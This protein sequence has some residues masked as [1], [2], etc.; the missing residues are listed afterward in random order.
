VSADDE[1]PAP[2]VSLEERPARRMA[3]RS[4]AL[5]AL[6]AGS[7]AVAFR[8]SD[9]PWPS[10]LPVSLFVA[11]VLL[12]LAL[13]VVTALTLVRFGRLV[14]DVFKNE[15]VAGRDT[16]TAYCAVTV[17]F[18]ISAVAAALAGGIGY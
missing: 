9:S 12:L 14:V 4:V 1:R 11:G 5:L 15:T 18:G 2:V 16:L 10:W 6:A 3:V 13:D 8:V 17:A 7:F